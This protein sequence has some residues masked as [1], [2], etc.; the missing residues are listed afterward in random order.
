MKKFGQLLF[1]VVPIGLVFVIENL[2]VLFFMGMIAFIEAIYYS[3]TGT[4]SF[5]RIFNDVIGLLVTDSFNTYVMVMYAIIA[6][7]LYGLWYYCCYEGDFHF[8]SKTLSPLSILGIVMLVPGTQYLTSYLISFL[9]SL[10]PSW[11]SAYEELLESAGMDDGLTFGMFLY[12]VLLAPLAEELICRGVT[13]NQ[14]RKVLPFWGANL[15]QAFLFGCFHMNMLQGSYAFC[16][17]LILGYIYYK[18]GSIYAS[19]LLHILFN[20]WGT[21]ISEFLPAIDTVFAFLF[22]FLFGLAMTIGGIAVFLTGIKNTKENRHLTDN[23]YTAGFHGQ[24]P[25][26]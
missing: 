4:A 24:N 20:F 22:W 3:L 16:L 25:L 7:A 26:Q 11:L 12:S 23:N 1:T 15:L 18:S 13:L 17:G 14:A 6:I 8:D 5:T 9:S 10:F 2:V 19:I 21:V